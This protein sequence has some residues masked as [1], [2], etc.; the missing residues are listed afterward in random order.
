[1]NCKNCG[2]SLTENDQFCKNCGAAVNKPSASTIN[3]GN[4]NI[5]NNSISQSNAIIKPDL[6]ASQNNV[7]STNNQQIQGQTS[8]QNGYNS[9]P[10][11]NQA[12]IQKNNGNTKFVV[13]GIIIAVVIFVGIIIIGSFSGDND[14]SLNGG[15]TNGTDNDSS[16]TS[17]STYMVKFK[18]FTFNIPNN[19]VYEESDGMLLIG[20]D[21]GTW[22]AQIEL[23]Q[24]NFT[25]LKSN[26]GQLQALM[27]QSGVTGSA[28]QEKTL[29]GVD[30][31]T[32]EI[33]SSGQKAIV[34]LAKANS[35][36]FVGIT[37][38]NQ[39]NEYDYS[40]LERIAP[41]ISTMTY[42]GEAHNMETKTKLDMTGIAGLAK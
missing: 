14:N 5:P 27:Q 8:W 24:G 26:K 29:G 23:E 39:N 22:M 6:M 31:I 16:Q 10:I 20:D 34:A 25:Q 28:A 18:G 40:L 15:L 4:S 2:Y 12:P 21:L 33:S 30:F 41:I 35:M 38:L 7:N 17:K 3:L 37:A 9:Q 13:I 1:M 19:L 11:Y 32:L 36:Y 42:N